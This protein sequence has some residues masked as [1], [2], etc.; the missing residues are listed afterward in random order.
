MALLSKV[1]THVISTTQTVLLRKPWMDCRRVGLR[2]GNSRRVTHSCLLLIA[3]VCLFLMSCIGPGVG[4]EIATFA[5][6][7]LP[8]RRTTNAGSGSIRAARSKLH[9]VRRAKTP[10]KW[11]LAEK[12]YSQS[13]EKQHHEKEKVEC[14][15]LSAADD[16]G[17]LHDALVED[18]VFFDIDETLLMPETPFIYGMPSSDSFLNRLGQCER[19]MLDDLSERMEEQYYT[20]PI[21]LVDPGIPSLI[22]GL[23]KAGK[24]VFALTSR[25]PDDPKYERHNHVE[26][27]VL[28]R[29]QIH[30][31]PLGQDVQKFG[32]D[33]D[34]GGIFYACSSD[35]SQLISKV[36]SKGT[37]VALVD[38]T[39]NKLTT[40]LDNLRV[41]L[42]GVHYTGA[43]KLE[44]SDE[45]RQDWMCR[46]LHH[47]GKQCASCVI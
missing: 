4:I 32:N 13:Q 17:T 45:A 30:F 9:Q 11:A 35:K 46:E 3:V 42:H 47:L 25:C 29:S 37:P 43:N 34:V 28:R 40:A 26:V 21:G 20:A 31:S 10:L 19:S 7:I 22:S 1:K 24:R 8:V 33:T 38:N 36:V 39:L 18:T 41:C 5:N 6:H 16:I 14:G 12:D 27:E 2:C 15:K 23:Q 44:Q